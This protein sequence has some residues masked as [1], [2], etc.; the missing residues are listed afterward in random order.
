LSSINSLQ[1]VLCLSEY[2]CVIG[3]GER[4]A[5]KAD[6]AELGVVVVDQARFLSKRCEGPEA[7]FSSFSNRQATSHQNPVAPTSNG[8]AVP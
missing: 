1:V 6:L 5:H 8:N 3:D 2:H 7:G 4:G